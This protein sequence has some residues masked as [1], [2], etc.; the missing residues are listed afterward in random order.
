MERF[1]EYWSTTSTPMVTQT[2]M[3]PNAGSV[4]LQLEQDRSTWLKLK[5][6][7]L[8][9]SILST[10]VRKW[11]YGPDVTS[12]HILSPP[13]SWLLHRSVLWLETQ[14]SQPAARVWAAANASSLLSWW[15]SE[16]SGDGEQMVLLPPA[17]SSNAAWL[18]K[19]SRD[20]DTNTKLANSWT[21]S[22]GSSTLSLVS[23]AHAACFAFLSS[24]SV[25]FAERKTE[26][27]ANRQDLPW[28][29][30]EDKRKKFSEMQDNKDN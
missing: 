13:F 7:Q 23:H 12:S 28:I 27:S 30:D 6:P 24:A 8:E 4:H 2:L 15:S 21:Y 9:H 5:L 16:L 20:L 26:T 29:F 19:P 22:S 1:S 25:L 14:A 3:E 10:R 11:L 17:T 18:K